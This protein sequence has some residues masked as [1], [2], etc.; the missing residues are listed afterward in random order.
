MFENTSVNRLPNPR[1]IKITP[2]NGATRMI[3]LDN[4]LRAKLGNTPIAR[5]IVRKPATVVK[6]KNIADSKLLFFPSEFR[7]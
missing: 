1:I 3:L 5:K 2:M 4:M 7:K 6:P